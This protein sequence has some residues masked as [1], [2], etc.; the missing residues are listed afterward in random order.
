MAGEYKNVIISN[1]QSFFGFANQSASAL[2]YRIASFASD[3]VDI[4]NTELSNTESIISDAAL[5]HRTLN[6]SYYVDIA[7]AYQGGDDLIEIDT[8]LHQL[9]YAQ[10]DPSKQIIKQASVSIQDNFITLNVAT[11]DSNNNLIP[12]T[13]DQLS[14]FSSYFN[15]VFR[16]SV[17]LI[18]KS[19]DADVIEIEQSDNLISYDSVISLDQLK[20][21]ISNKLVEIEQ[22][23]ILGNTYYVND[24][25][26]QLM[27]VDG[28][29]N[30]Y[31]GNVKV[32]SGSSTKS[33]SN[34]IS[35][36]SGYFN[37]NPNSQ[38]YFNYE[39]VS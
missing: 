32:T 15:N 23:V 34:K 16:K 11:T 17:W 4:I 2:W 25:V 8:V 20:Q 37:F 28:V 12:L 29:I 35:L 10:I 38:N 1:I 13:V 22:N 19:E 27:E 7:K 33:T 36:V 5:N 14:S 21:N 18:L 24:I 26:S 3:V 30:V 39:A 9:G 6:Q 31:I